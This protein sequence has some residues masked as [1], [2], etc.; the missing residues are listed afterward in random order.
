M[1]KR[2]YQEINETTL[3]KVSAAR[4]KRTREKWINKVVGKLTIQ[5]IRYVRDNR[6]PIAVAT[7]LCECGNITETALNS[8]TKNKT[9]SCGCWNADKQKLLPTLAAKRACFV[10]RR[11]DAKRRQLSWSLTLEQYS[12]ITQKNCYYCNK[13]P[14]NEYGSNMYNGNYKYSGIDRIDNLLGYEYHNCVPSCKECNAAKGMMSTAEFIQWINNINNNFIL[15]KGGS[16]R[17]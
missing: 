12:E 4:L 3:E 15:K 17:M 2:Q 8:I 6:Q 13:I 7:S 11:C 16:Y 10:S 5:H 9:L 14:S 1:L